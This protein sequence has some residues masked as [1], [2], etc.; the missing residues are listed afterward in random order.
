MA[1]LFLDTSALVKLYVAEPGTDN[2][3]RLASDPDLDPVV[4]LDLAIL[5]FRSAVRR[6]QRERDVAQSAAEQ[7]LRKAEHDASSVFLLQPSGPAVIEEALRMVDSYPLRAFDALQ[8]AGGL[9]AGYR[10]GSAVT[11]ACAD[12]TLCEAAR[13]EGLSVVNPIAPV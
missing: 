13:Q 1:V 5:E 11:F 10:A 7:I 2:V 6:R 4:I 12:T 9:V 8:L 3:V